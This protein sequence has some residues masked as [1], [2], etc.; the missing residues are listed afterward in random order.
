MKY[1]EGK[2]IEFLMCWVC[3]VY[4]RPGFLD[5]QQ[6]PD[7]NGGT[8]RLLYAYIMESAGIPFLPHSSC[9][10]SGAN[11]EIMTTHYESE[12]FSQWNVILQAKARNY[13]NAQKKWCS[14]LDPS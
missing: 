11:V 2:S 14:T 1:F 6:F 4:S 8:A 13:E 5:L 9:P 12:Q 3:K 10:G 7:E